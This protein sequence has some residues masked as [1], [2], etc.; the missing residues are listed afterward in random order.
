MIRDKNHICDLH[1]PSKVAIVGRELVISLDFSECL[2]ECSLVRAALVMTEMRP[3]TTRIQVQY[4]I[5]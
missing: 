5:W 3:D 2:Q 1:L 4:S